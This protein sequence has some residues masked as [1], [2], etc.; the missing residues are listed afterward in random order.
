M[1]KVLVLFLGMVMSASM[2]WADNAPKKVEKST[3]DKPQTVYVEVYLNDLSGEV[4]DRLAQEGALLKQAFM[5]YS[6]D[7]SRLYKVIVLSSDL[8]EKV[9]YLTEDGRVGRLTDSVIPD[10]ELM[11]ESTTGPESP[12]KSLWFWMID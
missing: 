6:P 10:R 1:K 12:L 3:E 7:G 9:M 5:T 8:K 2:M 11:P 4:L